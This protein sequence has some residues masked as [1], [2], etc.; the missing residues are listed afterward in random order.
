MTP[1]P[2]PNELSPS[3]RQHARELWRDL[4]D[5]QPD[6]HERLDDAPATVR[7]AINSASRVALLDG[8]EP[9][10]SDPNPFR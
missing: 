3:D 4:M 6:A 1:T 2:F 10:A 7:A 5:A 8:D 9:D